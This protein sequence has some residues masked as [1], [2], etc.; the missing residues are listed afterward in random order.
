VLARARA[1]ALS[2][3]FPAWRIWLDQACWHARRRDVRY[4]Q[5]GVIWIYD[6]THFTRAKRCAVAVLG[7]VTGTPRT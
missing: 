5:P 2:E 3:L 4:L 6:F 1:E 7:V